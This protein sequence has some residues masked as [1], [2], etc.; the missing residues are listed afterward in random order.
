MSKAGRPL[1]PI[2]LRLLLLYLKHAY[3]V[4]DTELMVRWTKNVR[5]QYF[6]GMEYYQTMFPSDPA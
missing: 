3:G 2:Q 5:W 4:G 6:S 1:L